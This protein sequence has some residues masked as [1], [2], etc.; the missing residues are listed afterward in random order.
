MLGYLGLEIGRAMRD[1]RYVVLALA[2]P[3]GF[4]LLFAAIFSGSQTRGG[5]LPAS[6]EVMVAMAAFGAE[7]GA[8]GA[9]APRLAR[10]RE[11]GWLDV[12]AVTPLSEARIMAARICAAML[13]SLPAVVAVGLA[14]R[15]A[16]AVQLTAGQWTLG[17][18]ALW[19]GVA[20]FVLLGIAIG[21]M[22]DSAT[23]YGVSMAA[24][25]GLAAVGGLWV[26][27]A[28]FPA[29][30]RH[31]AMALPSYNQAELGWRIAGGTGTTG[32]S[33]LVLVA[34]TV[35][36]AV[37][38]Y[39]AGARPALSRRSSPPASAGEMA[40]SLTDVSKSFG[41]VRALDHLSMDIPQAALVAL[42]GS[43]GA[44]KTTSI[45]VMLGLLRADHGDAR[46]FGSRPAAAIASGRVGAMLQDAEMMSGVKV[47]ALLRC[48]RSLY[49]NPLDYQTVTRL[50]EVEEI[51]DRR[52]D[53]LS[54]GQA[55]RVAFA[56]ALIGN[57]AILVLDE[58]TAGLDVQA[59][60]AFWGGIRVCQATGQTVLFST[61][62]LEE[63]D[64]NA[65]RVIV[66]RA[67]RTVAD[68]SPDQV[69][70]AGGSTA[71]VGFTW[72]GEPLGS[73]G[74]LPGVT[75]VDRQGRQIRLHTTDSDATIW[76]LYD[77]RDHITRLAISDGGMR[78]AF[79]SL[80][81]S[82]HDS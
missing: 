52:T 37:V 70:A 80:T 68:G 74:D 34:W 35:G 43:N 69:R 60:Q 48:I 28:V 57:P 61:H 3:V 18:F 45:R 1:I 39:W 56:V 27:P 47:G 42:L 73:L 66:I 79:L 8:L 17:L 25:F 51:L 10:D 2:A 50:A 63:A 64:Q 31:V 59:Q 26:P 11:R 6:V 49:P 40:V 5:A 23:A 71:I 67:G 41:T 9:T 46:L 76:S 36:L 13:A 75:A 77:H 55:Q 82:A 29:V 81:G 44:G 62:Y 38:A 22:T 33:V 16:H 7:W 20:P 30:L 65:D 4:Y 15:L 24:Y 32:G 54:T 78:A 72:L 21:V 53:R 14:A 58:P 19:L 12:L